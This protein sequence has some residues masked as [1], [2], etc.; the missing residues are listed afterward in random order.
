MERTGL[1][2][3]FCETPGCCSSVVQDTDQIKGDVPGAK[4][5]GQQRPSSPSQREWPG[6]RGG[7]VR[8]RQVEPEVGSVQIFHRNDGVGIGECCCTRKPGAQL[9]CSTAVSMDFV[10]PRTSIY[11]EVFKSGGPVT[12]LLNRSIVGQSSMQIYCCTFDDDQPSALHPST[13][14]MPAS[15]RFAPFVQRRKVTALLANFHLAL[16]SDE[17]CRGQV[18]SPHPCAHALCPTL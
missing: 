10:S 11:R 4:S 7:A 16:V 6:R 5:R 8:H 17:N 3:H 13:S 2:W 12:S 1:L 9:L 15:C 18:I 14:C